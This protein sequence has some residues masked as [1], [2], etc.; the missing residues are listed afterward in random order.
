MSGGGRG[1]SSSGARL[2]SMWWTLFAAVVMLV[3]ATGCTAYVGVQPTATATVTQVVAAPATAVSPPVSQRPTAA[4]P[5]SR[6]AED[7]CIDPSIQLPS[8]VSPDA[9]RGVVT[10]GSRLKEFTTPSGNIS[11]DM[12]PGGVTCHARETTMIADMDNPQ[13]D[14]VCDGYSLEDEARMLCHSD[15]W[16]DARTMTLAYGQQAAVSA[17]VCRAEEVGVTCWS[18]LTGHGFFLSKGRYASW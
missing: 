17:Y 9:C 10:A 12:T 6:H 3:G 4:A 18:G 15:D 13:G 5:P 8:F 1:L 7:G 16:D 11:C 14:G 2:R